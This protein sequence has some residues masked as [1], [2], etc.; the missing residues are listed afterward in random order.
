MGGG[1]CKGWIAAVGAD[2]AK[3][4]LPRRGRS[5]KEWIAVAGA[6]SG[7]GGLPRRGRSC[8]GLIQREAVHPFASILLRILLVA[9]LQ[10]A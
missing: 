3:S 10:F 2:S 6:D 5:R 7:K 9:M 4:G 8:K 1:F